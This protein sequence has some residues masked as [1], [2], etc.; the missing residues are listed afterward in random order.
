MPRT[1]TVELPGWPP[2]RALTF[3]DLGLVKGH[4]LEEYSITSL[5]Q[6]YK[7]AP[8]V[9][10]V[11][12]R[13]GEPDSS[14]CV[15]AASLNDSQ[16]D[17]LLAVARKNG[18]IEVL[19]PLNGDLCVSFSNV[20]D[21]GVHPE[22]D[23]T[24]SLHLFKKQ[25]LD[26]TYRTCTLLTCTTKG[27]ATM[28]SIEV[29]NSSAD[30]ASSGSSRTWNV[31]ASGN[32]LCSKVDGTE[33]YALFGGKGVEVN[34]WDLGTCSKIWTAKPPPKNRLGIFTPTWFTSTAFLDN[35]DHRKFVAGT[36]NHQVHLYDISAQRKPV[37]SFDFRETPIRAVSQDLDG[38]THRNAWKGY[39]KMHGASLRI[40]QVKT[41]TYI[42]D[43]HFSFYL[44][45]MRKL[46]GCFPGK[47]SGSIRS[48]ARHP[49]HPLLASCG[50]DGYL[51]FWDIKTRQ[52][53]SAV[54][55]KQH[56][57]HVI[58]YS[59]FNDQEESLPAAADL[60][61]H[62]EHDTNGIVIDDETGTKRVKRK[63]AKKCKE[64]SVK[65]FKEDEGAKK[66]KR[67]S[68]RV[69]HEASRDAS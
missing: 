11:V 31:C 3:D 41:V 49:V 4:C 12:E 38:H 8:T 62:E 18:A 9:P 6:F 34:L 42:V 20:S 16:S 26:C 27:N 54:F 44:Q 14:K 59:N 32:I 67:K 5:T 52:P 29:A 19:N 39:G 35:N 50:L 57:I 17:P 22:N 36:N 1:T 45:Q 40:L 37:I 2:L 47:C 23:P 48:T 25:R 21:V 28:S 33:N 58:F 30:S 63:K 60:L 13:R 69:K 7:S 51:R 10:K 24:V 64:S 65:E 56:L 55:L 46:L 53:L 43:L 66:S 61:Q 68:K 15:L